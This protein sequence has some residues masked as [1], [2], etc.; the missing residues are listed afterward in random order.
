MCHKYVFVT[1][2][3]RYCMVFVNAAKYLWSKFSEHYIFYTCTFILY[4]EQKE[5]LFYLHNFLKIIMWCQHTL[6][7]L[8]ISNYSI[9]KNLTLQ[10]NLKMRIKQ[11]LCELLTFRW[12]EIYMSINIQ[13]IPI[14]GCMYKSFSTFNIDLHVHV[15]LLLHASGP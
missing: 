15:D 8:M 1:Y 4:S 9:H 11:N 10:K 5:L 3:Q 13:D 12:N 7:V 6:D 14:Q 2:V